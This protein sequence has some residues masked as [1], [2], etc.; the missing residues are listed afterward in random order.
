V[1][2]EIPYNEKLLPKLISVLRLNNAVYKV[3]TKKRLLKILYCNEQCKYEVLTLVLKHQTC[4]ICGQNR[5]RYLV[6][7]DG[8][9]LKV[10]QVCK[11]EYKFDSVEFISLKNVEMHH[12]IATGLLRACVR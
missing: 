11:C 8:K 12:D 1:T 7:R 9:T 4:D 3:N 5:A 2:L 6:Q 10:C